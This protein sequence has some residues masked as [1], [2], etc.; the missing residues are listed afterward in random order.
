M[1]QNIIHTINSNNQE[2]QN[3]NGKYDAAYDVGT[4]SVIKNFQHYKTK[5]QVVH[6]TSKFRSTAV[7]HPFQHQANY[8]DKVEV[9]LQFL[10]HCMEIN[11]LVQFL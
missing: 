1:K 6:Q 2:R 9:S 3:K 11:S 5:M 4:S 7:Y 8:I 10:R